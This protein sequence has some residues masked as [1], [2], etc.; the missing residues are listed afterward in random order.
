MEAQ[1]LFKSMAF[2][3][4]ALTNKSPDLNQV[5]KI[6]INITFLQNSYGLIFEC[7]QYM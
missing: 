4:G 7:Q 3:E 5:L 2:I 1:Q 6:K